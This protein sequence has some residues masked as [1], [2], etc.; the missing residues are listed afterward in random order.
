MSLFSSSILFME[1]LSAREMRNPWK[2]KIVSA[3]VLDIYIEMA[4]NVRI[5]NKRRARRRASARGSVSKAQ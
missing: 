2:W 3:R 4:T 1:A 5:S